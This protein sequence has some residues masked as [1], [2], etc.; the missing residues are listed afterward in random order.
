VAT[1]AS[2]KGLGGDLQM[3]S[4]S[5]AESLSPASVHTLIPV[6][7][8]T[9]GPLNHRSETRAS[10]ELVIGAMSSRRITAF[11]PFL[12]RNNVALQ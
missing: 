4:Q 12:H 11:L 3:G 7:L 8:D 5:Q 6:P 2:A 1:K 10:D 9:G